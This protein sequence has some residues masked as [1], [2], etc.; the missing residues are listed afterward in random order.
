MTKTIEQLMGLFAGLPRAYGIYKID[1]PTA[2]GKKKGAALTLQEPVTVEVWEQ[3]LKGKI[4]IGIVPIRD[5]ATCV[6]GAIDIDDYKLDHAALEAKIKKQKLP[7]VMCRS[8]SGG[9]HLYAFFATPISAEAARELLSDWAAQLGYGNVE[10]FPKQSKLKS[11]NDTGNW[12]NMPYCGGE[13]TERYGIR[14]NKPLTLEEFLEYVAKRKVTTKHFERAEDKKPELL[15]GGP[16]CLQTLCAAGFPEGTRNNGL[17]ALGVYC[18]KRWPNDWE[19][20]VEEMNA[21][22]MNPPLEQAEVIGVIA[23]LQRK[24]YAYSCK[25]PPLAQHCQRATC[26]KREYGIGI[27]DAQEIFGISLENVLRLETDPPIYYADFGER[28]I[29]FMA[30]HITS[31]NLFR[32]TVVEQ[33]GHLILPVPGG[34]WFQFM[35]HV[36]ATATVVVAPPETSRKAHIISLVEDY[37]LEQVPGRVWEDIIDG[38]TL[39]VEERVY[40]RP[41]KF[42]QAINKEHHLKTTIS[43]VYKALLGAGV[44]SAKR[45]I[46]GKS[47]DVWSVPAFK[48]PERIKPEEQM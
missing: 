44:K 19:P 43:D 34:K 42:I 31:Q 24:E 13:K 18:R 35:A 10:I 36:C 6:F 3:H 46:G 1:D 21:A 25:Q 39:E 47:Y 30:D 40:F 22:F 48:R 9:A 27:K 16:P 7:L 38:Q 5:D 29:E 32:K 33:T 41:H 8:K 20:R 45:E 2:P 4:Q 26:I 23:H 28:R 17:F 37:C 12:I 14:D 11:I 15:D